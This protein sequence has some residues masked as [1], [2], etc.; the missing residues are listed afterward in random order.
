MRTAQ[1]GEMTFAPIGGAA[2]RELA[3]R[4]CSL[5]EQQLLLLSPT[6]TYV[7]GAQAVLQILCRPA[8]WRQSLCRLLRTSPPGALDAMYW[9]FARVRRLVS[10]TPPSTCP[11]AAP[12]VAR[13]FD[14]RP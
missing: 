3:G 7:Q 10:R 9:L 6:G 1:A 11:V 12:A 2:W 8:G 14:L 13:R 4:G 5:D